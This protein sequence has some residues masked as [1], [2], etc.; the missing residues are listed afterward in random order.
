M[1]RGKLPNIAGCLPLPTPPTNH[2]PIIY[3]YKTETMKRSNFYSSFVILGLLLASTCNINSTKV[4]D[5]HSDRETT[6]VIDNQKGTIMKVSEDMYLIALEN[7]DNNTRYSPCNLDDKW[8]VADKK[9]TFSGMVKEIFPNE[10]WPGTP[11]V[12]TK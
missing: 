6:E 1:G 11:F 8:K 5:C 9:I 7:S 10:R 12:I 4:D 3:V 2:L